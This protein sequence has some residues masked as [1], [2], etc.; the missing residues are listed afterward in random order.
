VYALYINLP[1]VHFLSARTV[2][3]NFFNQIYHSI[4]F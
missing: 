2:Q 3:G 4:D 1:F